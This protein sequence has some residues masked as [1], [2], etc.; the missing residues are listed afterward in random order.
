M[1]TV[2]PPI[3]IYTFTAR[4][5]GLVL[6]RRVD[7]FGK[8]IQRQLKRT[9]DLPMTE[10]RSQGIDMIEELQMRTW[11]RENFV[12][13]D[14]RDTSL[15]PVILEEMRRRDTELAATTVK[16]PAGIK[17]RRSLLSRSVMNA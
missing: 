8:P 3:S 15:H 14:Q 9:G 17:R 4:K 6:R 2:Q 10:S 13:A 1:M 11:A 7:M 12:E 16:A 5:E